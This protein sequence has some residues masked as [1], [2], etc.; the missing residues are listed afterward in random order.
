LR[1]ADRSNKLVTANLVDRQRAL[2]LIR[3]LWPMSALLQTKII[4]IEVQG[5]ISKTKET[6]DIAVVVKEVGEGGIVSINCLRER[7]IR[8]LLMRSWSVEER[9]GGE[10]LEDIMA[11]SICVLKGLVFE[12]PVVCL[13]DECRESECKARL[14]LVR[15]VVHRPNGEGDYKDE[16][17]SV[18]D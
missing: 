13:P 11:R 10:E 16:E 15:K 6:R 3:M 1:S 18:L 12:G 9:V 4:Q 14:A 7:Y 5:I 17:A 8:P 2:H